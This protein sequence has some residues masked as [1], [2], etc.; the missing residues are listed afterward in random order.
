MLALEYYRSIP[1]YLLAKSLSSLFPRRFFPWAVPLRLKQVAFSKPRRDWVVLRPLLCGI[2]GSDLNLLRGVES[3]LLEPYAS[4][5]CIL[6]HEVVAEVVEAPAESGFSP[7]ERVAVEPILACR[8]RG[9]APCRFCARGDYNLCER[10]IQ[11]ELPPGV[12]LGFTNRAGGGLAELMAAPPENLF[13]L[14]PHLNDETAVLTDSLASAL[15]PVLDNFPP[16]A[17]T[18]VI[19]GAGI[20]GQHLVRGLR[21]LGCGARLVMVARYPFQERLAMAGGA[22]LVLMQPT[23]RQLGEALGCTFLPTT[24]GGGNL[25][26]G[27]DFFFDC[28]GSKNSL[29]SGLLALRARG[30]LVLVGTAGAV[31]SF[32]ISSL[33]FRELR[34]TGSAMYAY[35]NVRGERRRTYQV[36]VD[37]LAGGSFPAAGLLTHTFPLPEYRQVFQT[38]L[39]KRRHECVKVAVD[40]RQKPGRTEAASKRKFS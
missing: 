1:R 6:G 18:V 9:G 21:A 10:F 30:T 35:A 19:Y 25:E 7:G 5:P 13:R 11:G 33:W 23:R 3:Y 8:A 26:G 37:L 22:D 39:D 14:P 28:V 27:A 20:I 16:D 2:C 31:G 32:D 38:A 17:A 34:V 40:L 15:Q 4:F 24:L 36:A 29:Q 12:I